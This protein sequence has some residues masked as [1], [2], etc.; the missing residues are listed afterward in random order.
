MNYTYFYS[1]FVFLCAGHVL[2]SVRAGPYQS[3]FL[4]YAYR[5][6]QMNGGHEVAPGCV[7]NAVDGGG[8]RTGKCTFD[9]FLKYIQ[10]VGNADATKA[11]KGTTTA[12]NGPNLDFDRVVNELQTQGTAG[13]GETRYV[14]L[15]TLDTGVNL[16]ASML[17]DLEQQVLQHP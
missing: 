6:D 17:A 9:E 8:T 11:W 12:G 15:S 2:G 14:R 7:G 5:L 3:M 13:D 4:W 1:F 10:R 16:P